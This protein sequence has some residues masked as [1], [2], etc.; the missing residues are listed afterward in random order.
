MLFI[1]NP[2]RVLRV[3]LY[4]GLAVAVVGAVSPR[5]TACH[6]SQVAAQ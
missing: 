2:F 6:V 3:A 5:E 1:L 4:F